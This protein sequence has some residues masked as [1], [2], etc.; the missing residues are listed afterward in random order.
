MIQPTGRRVSFA[1]EQPAREHAAEPVQ[2]PIQQAVGKSVGEY[3]QAEERGQE[4]EEDADEE[5]EGEGRE[6]REGNIDIS[7]LLLQILADGA[8]WT[9]SATA[10]ITRAAWPILRRMLRKMLSITGRALVIACCFTV[11]AASFRWAWVWK[12]LSW[13]LSGLVWLAGWLVNMLTSGADDTSPGMRT[14]PRRTITSSAPDTSFAPTPIPEMRLPPSLRM[15]LNDMLL[16]HHRDDNNCSPDRPCAVLQSICIIS[17]AALIDVVRNNNDDDVDDDETSSNFLG[18]DRASRE[19]IAKDIAQELTDHAAFHNASASALTLTVL[20]QLENLWVSAA[21][22]AGR[23]ASVCTACEASRCIWGAHDTARAAQQQRAQQVRELA[24]RLRAMVG[25]AV[26]V[27]ATA[28]KSGNHN[29]HHKNNKKSNR[30]MKKK[31]EERET[32]PPTI[33]GL[34]TRFRR[35]AAS[36]QT[37]MKQRHLEFTAHQPQKQQSSSWPP[38]W[39]QAVKVAQLFRDAAEAEASDALAL[40]AA[41]DALDRA[42]GDIL[43]GWE[44]EVEKKLLRRVDDAFK[45]RWWWW[46]FWVNEYSKSSAAGVVREISRLL[47]CRCVKWHSST[48]ASG[49]AAAASRLEDAKTTQCDEEATVV[50]A[51]ARAPMADVDLTLVMVVARLQGALEPFFGLD[52][53]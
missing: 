14:T 53:I 27:G 24:G 22:L 29:H 35:A 47:S 48:S 52:V 36:R 40:W 3:Q 39:H 51:E 23:C 31:N 32:P 12:M 30:M 28:A 46:W 50:D 18:L 5:E 17:G 19:S 42:A 44:V 49:P 9:A 26:E 11:L 10:F 7:Y 38:R 43:D 37:K 6:E 13:T 33:R 41:L 45:E 34:H 21:S 2:Q 4:E 8:M 1:H 20:P 25:A 15:D 16:L